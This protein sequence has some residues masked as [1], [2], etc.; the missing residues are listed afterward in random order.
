MHFPFPVLYSVSNAFIFHIKFNYNQENT[1]MGRLFGT[2][3]IRGKANTYPITPE[4][5]LLVG[6]AV[7]AHFA[8]DSRNGKPR[9]VVGKDTR[10]S[11]YM[12]ENAISA[13][14]LSMGMDVLAVGP[15][16]TPA[17]AHLVRSFAADCGI[18]ITASHNPAGDNGIK[19]FDRNGF[20]LSDQE[21]SR[22]EHLI[23]D[24]E[25][26]GSHI[27]DNRIG[28]A[29]RIDDARGRYIEF[30]KSSIG[31]FPL[32]G[33]KMVLDCAHGAAYSMAPAIF[34]ELG[35]EVVVCGAEPDGNNINLNCGA[36]NPEKLCR[37]VKQ[38]HADLGAALDG[39]ADRVI[40]CDHCGNIVDGDRIIGMVALDAKKRNRL[41]NNTC[42]V[43][44]MTNL[45]F[46]RAMRNAGIDVMTT[47][48]GDHLVIE[49]M[50][51]NNCSIGGE[52]SGHI[53]FMDF[54]TTGDG[55]ITALHIMKLM[56]ERD[57]TLQQLADF[58]QPFPQKLINLPVACKRELSEMAE[59]QKTLSSLHAALGDSGRAV[60]RFSGTEN[61]I[62]I[63][64]ETADP[65]ELEVWSKKITDAV[66]KDLQ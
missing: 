62:R 64:T 12:L 2:D 34:R 45:G 13:G 59:T 40:F 52:Q 57:L 11:G 61:K 10:L 47:G 24:T 3:G 38:H 42:V 36:T 5:A 30:A 58:M 51:K 28:K 55:I 53:V 66:K 65:G 46:H 22:L 20:K 25:L 33:L 29:R 56:K 7:A 14:L 17:V 63:L 32:T 35:A 23:L 41:N 27:D 16:P 39:D 6:K 18:M 37:L 54:V 8:P 21:T 48:V 19:I 9:A 15:M 1:P 60:V 4:T 49:A 26:S 44:T 43:T 50:R 31:N